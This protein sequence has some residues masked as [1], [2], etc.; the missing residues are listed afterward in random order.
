M[1]FKF[2]SVLALFLTVIC[3]LPYLHAA[4][5]SKAL[6]PQYRHWLNEEV[7]YIIDGTEKK[8]FLALTTDAQ[9][10]TFITAFW[11][12]RNPDADPD[13]N[14]YK[15]EHYRRLAYVN[16]HFGRLESRDGWRTDQGKIYIILGPPKQVVTYP[17]ARNVRPIEIWFY[18]SPSR[19]LPPY[20]NIV[21][22]KRSATE[23]Y[24]LYS[25]NQDGPARLVASLEAMN[26]QN[27]SLDILRKSLGDEVAKTSLSLIPAESVNFDDYKPSLA[28]DMLLS[29]IEGLPD[30][31]LTQDQLNLNRAR[32][33][34]TMSLFLG[35]R[36]QR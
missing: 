23:P 30:N 5:R 17:L 15:D 4:D 7:N 32:E 3:L 14:S 13:T 28:S 12:I 34:V 20:F 36:K 1:K 2:S 10:D 22:Y 8:Q 35:S 25:P 33:H 18:Q 21:F 31:P 29:T 9:R 19:A 26:D 6:P 11:K 24:S 16:E 27:K